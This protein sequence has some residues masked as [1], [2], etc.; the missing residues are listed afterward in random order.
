VEIRF[1]IR[2]PGVAVSRAEM[3]TPGSWTSAP[4][5]QPRHFVKWE[6]GMSPDVYPALLLNADFRPVSLFPLSLLSWQQAVADMVLGRVSV[7]AEYDRVVRSPSRELRLPSV[8]ALR[9]YA[10]APRR[11]AFTRYNV[12]LRDRFTCQY[13]QERLP[14][15]KLTFD[16]VVP[17]S[18]GGATSWENVVAACGPCNTAKGDTLAMAPAKAPRVPS[19]RELMAARKGLPPGHLH[20]SWLDYL[21]WD[22]ELEA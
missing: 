17:R 22:S 9:R 18:R 6:A 5:A 1:E 12:F 7:V 20:A 21:Y 2:I 13:C 8:V 3:A 11:I 4:Y 15:A 16:H 19:A 14:A 10:R